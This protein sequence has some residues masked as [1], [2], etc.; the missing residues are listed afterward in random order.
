MAQYTPEYHPERVLLSAREI[1]QDVSAFKMTSGHIVLIGFIVDTQLSLLITHHEYF[2]TVCR[3]NNLA[4][5]FFK[6]CI[7]TAIAIDIISI[8]VLIWSVPI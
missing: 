2:I 6:T 7:I 8:A 5:C 1:P 4:S 3:R